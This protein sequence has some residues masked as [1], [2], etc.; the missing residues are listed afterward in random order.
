M[1]C[2]TYTQRHKTPLRNFPGKKKHFVNDDP[3]YCRA[4]EGPPE[5]VNRLFLLNFEVKGCGT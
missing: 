5:H 3:P 1:F 4:D 2:D